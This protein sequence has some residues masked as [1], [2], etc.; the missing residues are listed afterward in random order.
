MAFISAYT[1][2]EANLDAINMSS[3]TRATTANPLGV[4]WI[5]GSGTPVSATPGATVTV[6][7]ANLLTGII[8]YSPS[9]G[10]TATFDT[11]A[12][13]VAA[14]NGATAGAVV[15]DYVS[16]LIVNGNGTNA[17]TLA[18]GSGGNF[19]TN[20]STRTI[21]ANTS[22]WVIFRLTNVTPGSEAYM[23]YF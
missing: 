5:D 15:G 19:D 22:K 7:A 10:N 1:I 17:I 9:T 11:A 14:V 21:P 20:Q 13:I 12:N 6:T 3:R 18:A 8:T 2:N 4:N 16:T 23:I